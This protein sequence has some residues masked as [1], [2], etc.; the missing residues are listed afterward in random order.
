MTSVI[1]CG[2]DLEKEIGLII[3]EI[4]RPVTPEIT[5]TTQ[6]VPGM[7]GSL[8][9]GNNYGQRVFDIE[10]TIKAQSES[11]RVQKI[12][13]LAELAMTFGDGEFPMNFGDESD[14][15][16]YGHFTNVTIPER[17]E[18]THW[19]QCTLTFACSD[20]K[21]YGEYENHDMLSNP[22][23]ISPNGTAECYPIFTCLPKKDVTKIA[24]TDEEGN[25]VYL[26]AEVD[27]DTGDSP[28]NKEPL[29]LHD[30]CNTLATWTEITKSNLTFALENGIPSGQMRSTANAIKV[31]VD[32]N[33]VS[34]FGPSTNDYKWHG[35]VRQQWL[36]N[37]Y[38]DFRLLVRMHNYQYYP[39]ARGKCEVYLLDENGA[40]MGKIMLKD[41]GNSEEV[42]VHFRL[43][44]ASNF[45]DIY[46][47][48]GKVTK[49][50]KRTKTIKL[51]A[52][53]KKVTSKGKTKTVQ[54]WKTVKLDEDSS[55]STFTDFYGYLRL[56]KIGNKYQVYI[57]KLD[58][59]SNPLWNKPIIVNWT[60]TK[61]Q[62]SNKKLAGIAFYTA[63]M[64]I[65]EDAANPPKAYKRNNM[66]LTDVKVWNIIDGGNNSTEAPTVIA[67]K[68]DEIKINAED[69]TVYKNGA[70][71]MEK[72][73]IGS[74]FPIMQGGIQKAFAF[75]P[76]LDEAD[77]YYEYRP[78]KN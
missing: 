30:P 61:N 74:D 25:Y 77:W 20:P 43:G 39:R 64:D 10:I 67:H 60:D 7:V 42:E 13:R 5:E 8:F 53:T 70:P 3:N 4:K 11:E 65:T 21:G 37:A 36:P 57:L 9:L 17:I 24:I 45:K 23:T 33:G 68:G 59:D 72:F 52:G 35:P 62:F 31:A 27:P 51:G 44:T 15:T 47:G 22:T 66:A 78:T 6:D 40:R 58:S 38:G 32:A 14:I 16:F 19:A 71:F 55:T 12:H 73:Y 69:R 1:F 41:V 46:A 2:I 76:D 75:E 48:K 54:Q 34:N 29:V 49:G 26:G 50:K 28:I 63:K 18:R 56:Q